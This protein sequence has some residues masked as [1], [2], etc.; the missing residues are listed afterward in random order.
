MMKYEITLAAII[1]KNSES[2]IVVTS[3]PLPVLGSNAKIL[4]H[5]F[6]FDNKVFVAKFLTV[7][8]N[9]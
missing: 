7:L 5:N 1:A 6:Y 4:Q 3:L 8:Y 9:L 2:D